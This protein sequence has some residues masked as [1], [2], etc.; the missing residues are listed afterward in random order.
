MALKKIVTQIHEKTKRNYLARMVLEKK[1]NMKISK[2]M[3]INTGMEI[4]NMDM[5]VLN[6][7]LGI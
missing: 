7:Y 1:K 6:I 5:E 2:N 3:I 4:V